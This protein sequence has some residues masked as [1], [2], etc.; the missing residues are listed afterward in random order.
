MP[1]PRGPAARPVPAP[2]R[3]QGDRVAPAVPDQIC[4]LAWLAVW[5]L[6]F[7]FSAWSAGP[8]RPDGAALE[9]QVRQL[10]RAGHYREA[11]PLALQALQSRFQ[12]KGPEHPDTAAALTV[13]G[14]LYGELDSLAEAF[15]LLNRALQIRFKAL[16]VSHPD[17]AASLMHLGEVYRR[18]GALEE[19]RPLLER[20]FQLRQ[21]LLGADH[22][23]TATSLLALA[24]YYQDKGEESQVL[25]LLERALA[26]REKTLGHNSPD[27]AA[28]LNLVGEYHRRRGRYQQAL[29]FLEKA[30]Q[31][32]E[33]ALG[34]LHPATAQSLAS[35]GNLY[36]DMGF[37][38][39]AQAAL[40]QALQVRQKALGLEHPLAV[41]SLSDLGLL[42]ARQ[43]EFAKARPLLER[44]LAVREQRRPPEHPDLAASYHDLAILEQAMGNWARA[45]ALAQQ[46]LQ[47]R[48]RSLGPSHVETLASL[49]TLAGVYRD[50]G[51]PAKAVPLYSRILQAQEKALGTEHPDLLA[52]LMTLAQTHKEAGQP[53]QTLVLWQRLHQIREKTS[54]AEHPDTLASLHTLAAMALDLGLYTKALAWNQNLLKIMEKNPGPEHS[55]TA[56][57]LTNVAKVYQAMGEFDLGLPLL[58]RAVQIREKALGPDHPDL[59]GTYLDLASLRQARGEYEQA[60]LLIQKALQIREK[61]LGADHPATALALAQ[62]A[63]LSEALGWFAPALALFE[64]SL[65]ALAKAKEPSP[66]E[67]ALL[68]VRLATLLEVMGD[69]AK[70]L[71]FWLQAVKL[72]EPSRDAAA[73]ETD[74]ILASLGFGYL[75]AGEIKKAEAAFDRIKTREVQ[76][77]V[78]LALGR[79]AEAWQLLEEAPPPLVSSPAFQVRWHTQKGRALAG[80]GMLPEAAVALWEAV[81][82]A[83]KLSPWGDRPQPGLQAWWQSRQP[84]ETLL[85]VLLRLDAQGAPLPPELQELGRDPRNAAFALSALV[86]GQRFLAAC[87]R[88]PAE[89]QRGDLAPE[90]QLRLRTL[91]QR[92]AANASQWERA[93]KGG[94]EALAEAIAT[95]DRLIAEL[96]SIQA[97]LAFSQPLAAALY[98]PPPHPVSNVPLASDE[99]LIEYILGDAEGCILVVRPSEVAYIHP[100]PLGRSA[101]AEKVRQLLAPV[102]QADAA[103]WSRS[104]AQELYELLLAKPLATVAPWEKIIIIPDGILNLL[105][106]EA[107]ISA[108]GEDGAPAAFVGNQPTVV[109]YPST[110][111]LTQQRGR[112]TEP[113]P[114]PFLG[115]GQPWTTT[116]PTGSPLGSAGRMD[117]R[118]TPPLAW[119][120]AGFRAL[121]AHKDWGPTTPG[122]RH[123]QW[124]LY[125]LR[126]ASESMLQELA[127]LFAKNSAA[128][129]LLQGPQATAENLRR[130]PLADYKFLHVAAATD[131]SDV[132]QGILQPFLLLGPE[133]KAS[134]LNGPLTLNAILE[135]P[136][137]AH[138]VALDNVI[139]GRGQTLAGE[140][141]SHLTRAFLY[142]GARS[143]LV[144]LWPLPATTAQ[145]FYQQ[146]YTSLLDG[147]SPGQ[148]VFQARQQLRHSHPDPR[149]WAA[150]Q[151]WGE[152]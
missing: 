87:N 119:T 28:S 107:L 150:W 80:V 76:I 123:D 127:E 94:K 41:Q 49:S 115:V 73:V 129:D 86:K 114:R 44:A 75:E 25:P 125:P 133:T 22:P 23:E 91:Q 56:A 4:F 5:L 58:E 101:L 88:A 81:Q 105:P 97:E 122:S 92:L 68:A 52:T 78:A 16:G 149:L 89:I 43:K 45:Q 74:W 134:L 135:L 110:A 40:E 53:D 62:L 34:K 64:Q 48:E 8:P 29:P 79:Y 113:K 108:A 98:F 138:L 144:N 148:A 130:A 18:Q 109:Y 117:F 13:A 54:G 126:P 63:R 14:L 70:A 35:L 90:L 100:L 24:Q 32:H 132:I 26:I 1:L 42:Y 121:A 145:E 103:G 12:E 139:I 55:A 39:K 102:L 57:A 124:L 95:R 85:S 27:L 36:R 47:I 10:Q 17:T 51:V 11:L 33:R 20:S 69:S 84:Q 6:L 137:G 72:T 120:P 65:A 131:C 146:V 93:V 143:V 116:F 59:A 106:F 77:E 38:V 99:V 83:A 128:P 141:V 9:E 112:P 152:E 31:M 118:P 140:G 82:G 67:M 7:P 111:V 142:A 21:K 71:P 66:R 50:L 96:A 37:Y 30:Q 2:R 15:S 60:L 147:Q 136:L 61:V 104:A 46:A 19:A 3:W 151:L